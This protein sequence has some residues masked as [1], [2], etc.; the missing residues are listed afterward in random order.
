MRSAMSS[1]PKSHSGETAKYFAWL[2][3]R[4]IHFFKIPKTSQNSS[5]KLNSAEHIWILMSA[6]SLHSLYLVQHSPRVSF[7]FSVSHKSEIDS[8]RMEPLGPSQADQRNTCECRLLQLACRSL[9]IPSY[10]RC[11]LSTGKYHGNSQVGLLHRCGG[12][13]RLRNFGSP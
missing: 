2:E 7:L 6:T 9:C 3:S 5:S 1:I 12:E 10:R 4:G 11:Y 8:I 13:L